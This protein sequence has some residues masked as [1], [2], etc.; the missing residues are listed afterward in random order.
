MPMTNATQLI[1]D[2]KAA[3]AMTDAQ[4]LELRRAFGADMAIDGREADVIFELD[5]LATKPDGWADYFT[6]ILTTYLVHQGKPIGY[7]NDAIAAWLIARIDHDGVVETETELRLLMNILKVAEVPGER[8]ESYALN[9]VKEAVIS[10]RG[11]VGQDSLTPGIIGKAEIE[12]L[13]RIFYGVGGDGGVGISRMEAQRIFELNELTKGRDND[14]EWQRFFVGAIA[15]HLMMIAAP[16]KVDRTEVLRREAW[17]ENTDIKTGGIWANFKFDDFVTNLREIF[18][19]KAR[20]NAA[21]DPL[22]EFSQSDPTETETILDDFTIL[23]KAE[24]KSSERVTFIESQWL[25]KALQADGEFDDNERALIKFIREEC[26][27][28]D[29]SLRPLIDAA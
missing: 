29:E 19:S 16:G 3:N 20:F 4:L 12:V 23:N 14:P 7:I 24:V 26:P 11:R 1:A 6:L 10:G 13:R 18:S 27:D 8:L 17:L 28:I 21:I 9:Q 25:I 2:M 22:S 15:N 5:K